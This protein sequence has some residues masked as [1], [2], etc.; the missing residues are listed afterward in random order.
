[1]ARRILLPGYL[2]SPRMH[3][4]MR[5]APRTIAVTLSM[6]SE[7]PKRRKSTRFLRVPRE[8]QSNMLLSYLFAHF[9]I[10]HSK[11]YDP[12]RAPI[13]NSLDFWKKY[14]T[15]CETAMRSA[16]R[17]GLELPQH[18]RDSGTVPGFIPFRTLIINDSFA[19]PGA[20]LLTQV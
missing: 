19:G 20:T 18:L 4:H 1:M 17:D 2:F 10:I 3:M 9:E 6:A 12:K 14:T 16:T 11:N 13:Y 7:L 5:M 8:N 15:R